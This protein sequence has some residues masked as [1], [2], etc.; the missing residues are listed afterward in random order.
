MTVI[1]LVLVTAKS[2]RL[3]GDEK[4]DRAEADSF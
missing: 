3:P 2:Y 4:R 1:F